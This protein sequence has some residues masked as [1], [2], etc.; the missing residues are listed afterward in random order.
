M[1]VCRVYLKFKLCEILREIAALIS[2]KNEYIEKG[3]QVTQYEAQ[4]VELPSV[5]YMVQG[6]LLYSTCCLQRTGVK[7]GVFKLKVF[8]ISKV[9]ET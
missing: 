5:S 2:A 7:Q 6:C 9:I 3:R 1:C 8:S 4:C